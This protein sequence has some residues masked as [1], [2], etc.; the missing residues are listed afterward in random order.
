MEVGRCLTWGRD[1]WEAG[2]AAEHIGCVAGEGWQEGDHCYGD[3][4]G[5]FV[6]KFRNS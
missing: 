1:E 2:V 6:K 3:G 4:Q 5:L